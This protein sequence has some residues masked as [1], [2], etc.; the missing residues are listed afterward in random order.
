MGKRG[1]KPLGRIKTL[2]SLRPDQ[3]KQLRLIAGHLAVTRGEPVDVSRVLRA[4]IDDSPVLKQ[5]Y[6]DAAATLL[7]GLSTAQGRNAVGRALEQQDRLG[8]VDEAKDRAMFEAALSGRAPPVTFEEALAIGADTTGLRAES[9]PHD[10]KEP[11]QSAPLPAN[12]RRARGARKV[13]R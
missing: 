1:P 8:V 6:L 10:E 5:L 7:K 13:K 11:E 3:V 9:S 4:A 2:V 12:R